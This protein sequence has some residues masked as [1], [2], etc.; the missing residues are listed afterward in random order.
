[1]IFMHTT[2]VVQ[3][4]LSNLATCS[5]SRQVKA[6]KKHKVEL[7][8]FSMSSNNT[9]KVI[10]LVFATKTS[11]NPMIQDDRTRSAAMLFFHGF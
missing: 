11:E 1:M 4:L 9:R 7:L 2:S 8:I 6:L 10:E 5:F 3:S